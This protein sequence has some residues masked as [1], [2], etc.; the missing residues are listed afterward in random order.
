MS[1]TDNAARWNAV[2][3][4]YVWLGLSIYLL[5]YLSGVYLFVCLSIYLFVCLSICLSI[6]LSTYLPIYLPKRIL[7]CWIYV[8]LFATLCSNN[9]CL[10]P[11]LVLWH[12]MVYYLSLC[13]V[14]FSWQSTRSNC[15]LCLP[16]QKQGCNQRAQRRHPGR[17]VY[18]C[19]LCGIA[20][21]RKAVLEQSITGRR[22]ALHVRDGQWQAP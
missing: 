17:S 13:C 14:R 19:Q 12:L 6:Y 7:V 3:L 15:T 18:Y 4:A 8:F 20:Q 5:I 16:C 2:G 10:S 21:H 9:L 22:A 1:E 11:S